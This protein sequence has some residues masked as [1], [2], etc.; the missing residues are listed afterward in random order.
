MDGSPYVESQGVV[1]YG[2]RGASNKATGYAA[3]DAPGGRETDAERYSALIKALTGRE[4]RIT[5]KSGG[6]IELVCGGGHLDGFKRF[7]ELADAV[8]RWLEETER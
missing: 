1:T 4:P 7:A 3:A 6:T 2:E 5:E 8:E